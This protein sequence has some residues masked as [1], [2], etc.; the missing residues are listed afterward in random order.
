MFLERAGSGRLGEPAY[1]ALLGFRDGDPERNLQTIGD[2]LPFEVLERFRRNAGFSRAQ[3]SILMQMTDR[4][5]ALRRKEGCFRLDES[6]RLRRAARAFGSALELFDGE[7]AAAR[8][9]LVSPQLALGGEV[10]L[11]LVGTESGSREVEVAIGR[12]EQGVYG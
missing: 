9:W 4:A 11:H 12:I 5:L 2:R 10:P 3:M 1:A 7:A 8:E 6:A